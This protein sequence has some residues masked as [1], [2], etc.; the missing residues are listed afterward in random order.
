MVSYLFLVLLIVVYGQPE[1]MS[2]SVNA[3]VFP[4]RLLNEVEVVETA[5]VD[6]STFVPDEYESYSHFFPLAA[7]DADGDAPAVSGPGRRS[8]LDRC[9]I[10]GTWSAPQ[11]YLKTVNF[12][13]ECANNHVPYEQNGRWLPVAF[14]VEDDYSKCPGCIEQV[15][16]GF[17]NKRTGEGIKDCVNLGG[18]NFGKKTIVKYWYLPKG[19]YTFFVQGSWDYHCRASTWSSMP[20]VFW[21]GI[22]SVQD[23]VIR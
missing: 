15:H 17:W 3:K 9:S 20:S 11:F 18:G 19:E 21:R 1:Q 12:N 13:S 5:A 2:R 6:N 16:F 23:V 14:E 8:L 10:V 4:G 7:A 22:S